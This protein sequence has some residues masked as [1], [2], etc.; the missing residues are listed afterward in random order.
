M[1][2]ILISSLEDNLGTLINNFS[3]ALLQATYIN[4][5]SS[6]VSVSRRMLEDA[7]KI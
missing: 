4:I 5:V 3:L 6:P 1:L 2:S 7:L